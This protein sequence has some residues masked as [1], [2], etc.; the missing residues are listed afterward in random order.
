MELPLI[1]EEELGSIVTGV[2]VAAPTK[3]LLLWDTI[4]AL[5]LL[6]DAAAFTAIWSAAYLYSCNPSVVPC[7]DHSLLLVMSMCL[8][9]G[10][11]HRRGMLPDMGLPSHST[12]HACT[13]L[14]FIV[15]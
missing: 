6:V 12:P 14:P 5:M 4:P 3:W 2:T 13:E 1:A 9:E 15:P 11:K 10:A 7:I 8:C